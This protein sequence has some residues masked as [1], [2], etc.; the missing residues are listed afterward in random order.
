[1]KAIILKA[2][3]ITMILL[4]SALVT[5]CTMEFTVECNT[6]TKSCTARGTIKNK[7]A[8]TVDLQSFN[9]A[10]A[11]LQLS[12]NVGLVATTGSVTLKLYN[13][14][15]LVAAKSFGWIRSGNIVQF[16]NPS[17]V[18]SWVQ[19]NAQPNYRLEYS[20][21]GMTYTPV[22]GAN[23]FSSTLFYAGNQFAQSSSGWSERG[24]DW[25]DE[26]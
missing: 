23:S 13:S 12:G 11:T 3:V 26:P 19:A 1:M 9:A 15:S 17:S 25:R 5:A 18:N 2:G 4:A 10:Q 8:T 14:S 6:G 21:N 22:Q 24:N 7:N 16:A 20:V